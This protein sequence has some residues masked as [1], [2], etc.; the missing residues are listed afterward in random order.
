MG[1]GKDEGDEEDEEEE[2]ITNV[3]YFDFAQYKCP[4]P[5]ALF[6]TP[7][8]PFCDTLIIGKISG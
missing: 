3:Q 7:Y 6:P 4:M 5:N 8:S 2:L 1:S